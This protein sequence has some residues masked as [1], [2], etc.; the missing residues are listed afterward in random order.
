M[1]AMDTFG[2]RLIFLLIEHQMTHMSTT[3]NALSSL[4][5]HH[6]F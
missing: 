4:Y 6:I 1:A 2:D 5:I 3:T